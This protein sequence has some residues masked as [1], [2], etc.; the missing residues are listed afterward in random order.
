[1]TKQ[2]CL[3]CEQKFSGRS[4]KKFCS[5]I[6]KNEFNNFKTQNCQTKQTIK[7]INQLLARNRRLLEQIFSRKTP[8]LKS[9]CR[10]RLAQKGFCFQFFTHALTNRNGET[11]YFCYDY[12]Y[13]LTSKNE[14][15]PL[16]KQ[17][18]D[19]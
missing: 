13:R 4:D 12:G 19:L 7:K 9:I 18:E 15:I 16:K 10:D 1:M 11:C 5:T 17:L 6:C 2:T 14:V 8:E 3:N